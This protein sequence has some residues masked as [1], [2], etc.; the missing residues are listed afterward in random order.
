M[1]QL[2]LA[3]FADKLNEIMPVIIREFARRHVD[4]ALYKGKVTLQQFFALDYLNRENEIKMTDLARFMNVTTAATTGIADR[5]VK[6][7]YI[8]RLSDPSDRRIIKIKITPKGSE[9]VNKVHRQ[10]RK[11]VMDIFSKISE[12]DRQDYLRILAKVKEELHKE[13]EEKL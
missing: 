2:S 8:L 12:S 9:L 10:R 7:G 6:S 5:L 11:T 4:D 1:S 13:K 3:D